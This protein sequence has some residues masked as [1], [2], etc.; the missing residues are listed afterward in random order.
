MSGSRPIDALRR[1]WW[2]VVA[3][4]IAGALVGGLPQPDS[5]ADATVR[6]TASHT[7]LV[8]DSSDAGSLFT[9]PLAFNQLQLFATTG[10]VPARAAEAIDYSGAPA[11]L[12]GQ[13][14][15]AADQQSGALRIT[16]TQ[17]SAD[18][19]VEVADAF[20]DELI[21]FLSERQ[22][23]LRETRLT[24]NLERLSDVETELREAE[25]RADLRPDDPVAKAELDA[26]TRQYGVIFEQ[27][28]VLQA[29]VGQLVLTT[30]ERA[31]AVPITEQGLGAP[32]S[33][34][35]RGT[36]GLLAG[37][38]IGAAV[39]LV[40]AR[41]DHKIRTRS[42]AEAVL[43]LE[44]TATI[45][46]VPK[47]DVSTI[48]V[49]PERHDALSDS[50]RTL[51][52]IVV[53]ADEENP[54]PDGNAP[55][56]LVVSPGS[57][58]GKTTIAANLTAAFAESG[59]RTLAINADF[60]R[61]AL[62]KR[63]IGTD[64][65]PLDM[66]LRT[67]E[68]APLGLLANR[69]DTPNLSVVDLSAAAGHSPSELARS[70]ARLVPRFAAVSDRI[71]VDTSPVGATAEVLEFV[72]HAQ[73]VLVAVRL[74]HTS[75]GSARRAMEMIRALHK[76]DV[77]LVIVGGGAKVDEYYYYGAQES[78]PKSRLFKRRSNRKADERE[79]VS[80]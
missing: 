2:V 4:G 18:D 30:L 3:F 70:S 49:V 67:L 50:Y 78:A 27:F 7:I 8:S 65:A 33:R 40:L 37:L 13:V 53:F 16:T 64:P 10:Q 56:T 66:S 1:F 77:L 71:V 20:G 74:G 26:L 61:P 80:V 72:R 44:A 47:H 28:S 22:D 52:S 60:R 46:A 24:A 17:A 59:Q 42:E 14:Q 19:A 76:G 69:S 55:V 48:S 5:A 45:P 62:T 43:G 31:E 15:V 51:R 32:R 79:T 9:N 57:G 29:D 38:T 73:T 36:F 25:D 34:V 21:G 75:I 54:P 58:D 41:S 68:A 35:G 12:A 23:E 63:L 11:A 6:W 39:A